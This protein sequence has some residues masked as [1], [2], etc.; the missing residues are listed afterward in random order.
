MNASYGGPT[1]SVVVSLSNISYAQTDV[2][3]ATFA[4]LA[5]KGNIEII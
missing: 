3:K 2:N 1:Y 4:R 5:Y